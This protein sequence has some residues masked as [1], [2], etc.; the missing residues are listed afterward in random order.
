MGDFHSK[1]NLSLLQFFETFCIL[2]VFGWFISDAFSKETFALS[3]TQHP[4][5]LYDQSNEQ[6]DYLMYAK[7]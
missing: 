5:C 3:V 2:G 4:L 6:D 1:L 7:F